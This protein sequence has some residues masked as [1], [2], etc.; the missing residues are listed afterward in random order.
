V[1]KGR[2]SQRRSNNRRDYGGSE[3]RDYGGSENRDYGGSENRDYGSSDRH[4]RQRSTN[5]RQA[6]NDPDYAQYRVAEVL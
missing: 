1:I 6:V 4:A 3:N 5:N 2:A